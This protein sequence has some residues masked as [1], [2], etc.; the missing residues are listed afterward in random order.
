MKTSKQLVDLN[1]YAA[2]F[3]DIV[4]WRSDLQQTMEWEFSTISWLTETRGVSLIMI[5]MPEAGKVFDSGLSTGFFDRSKLPNTFGSLKR[6]RRLLS[7]LF[8]EVFREDGTLLIDVDPN[9]VFFIRQILYLAK[10]VEMPCSDEAVSAAVDEF[11]RIESSTRQHT[12]PWDEDTLDLRALPYVDLMDGYRMYADLV[13]ERETCP[14]PLIQRMQEVSDRVISLFPE[15]D[16]RSI[17]PSHGP[18]SV[19]DLKSGGDKYSF[20]HWPKKLG[21]LFSYEYFA[22]SREDLHFDYDVV[23]PKDLE[24]PA[25]LIA[26][27]KTLKAPRMIASEPV[28]HQFLQQG[29]MRWLRAHLPSPVRKSV[30]FLDQDK[31]RKAA[32]AA[33][34]SGDMGTVDLSSASDRL[35]CWTVERVFRVNPSML[36]ALHAVRSRTVINGTGL[37][38]KRLV[39]LRKFAAQ[40]SA[41]TFPIQTIVYY[42]AS[43][44]ALLYEKGKAVNTQSV[45][46][47][48]R[49]VRVYGD[50]I[51]LPSHAVTSLA[52]LLTYLGLRV[53][54][55]KTHSKGYFR[56]SCGMDAYGGH[57]V[58]PTYLSSLLPGD[59]PS[60]LTS[61]VDVSNNAHERGLWYLSTWMADVIPPEKRRFIPTT[62]ENLGCI[63]LRTYSKGILAGRCRNN[64][65]LYRPEVLALCLESRTRLRKRDSHAN[66][67]QNFLDRRRT[68]EEVEHVYGLSPFQKWWETIFP[69]VPTTSGVR[70]RNRTQFRVRWV[71]YTHIG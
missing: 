18:G 22:Q 20:P 7:S 26:V 63:S 12:L 51:I 44:A 16:W 59:S 65:K 57:D 2:L 40:G 61:W 43:I 17:V 23:H 32:L 55:G 1:A 14:R 67:L 58:T 27:P 19:S 13:S 48:S 34:R 33:S 11:Y 56:E 64:R 29:L 50:D 39:L 38:G 49:N 15:L 8:S 68:Y 28:A 54:W 41:V 35:S 66:L 36:A 37:G 47:A 53:N 52:L 4:A 31:S 3:K 21:Q 9:L 5:D 6:K 62:D 24:P 42:C 70:M 10:K 25:K 46:A 30:D 60:E 69:C 71:P 45:H